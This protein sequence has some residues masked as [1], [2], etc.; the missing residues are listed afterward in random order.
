M[1]SS[2][3]DVFRSNDC[4]PAVE[5]FDRFLYFSSTLQCDNQGPVEL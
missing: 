4:F 1:F 5:R 3:A 2:I